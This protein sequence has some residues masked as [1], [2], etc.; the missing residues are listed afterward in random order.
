MNQMGYLTGIYLKP[1][2]KVWYVIPG[3][4]KSP[5]SEY[6]EGDLV[7]ECTVLETQDIYSHPDVDGSIWYNR[8]IKS[9]MDHVS[10]P[11]KETDANGWPKWKVERP[12]FVSNLKPVNQLLWLDE[13][14][15]HGITLGDECFLTLA[16]AMKVAR[17]GSKKHLRQRLLRY[18]RGC[19]K[20]PLK[21]IYIKRRR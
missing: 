2:D 14:I 1:G 10:V 6:K 3:A 20:R 15:G 18:R 21:K 12:S 17:A 4:Y 11:T 5:S 7:V 8:F 13:P 19:I 9:E 16:D